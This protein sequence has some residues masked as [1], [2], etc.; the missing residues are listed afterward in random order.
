MEKKYYVYV[1]LNPMRP[2]SYTYEDLKFDFEPFYVGKGHGFRMY[3]HLT[4]KGKNYLKT[5]QIKRILNSGLEPKIIKLHDNLEEKKAFELE[6]EIIKKI[7]RIDKG[8]GCLTNLTDGGDGHS[9]LIQSDETKKKRA[10]SRKKSTF[11]KTMKSKEFSNKMSKVAK[12]RFEDERERNKISFS[13]LGEKNP[14]FGKTTSEKQKEAV[15]KAHKEGK[16]KL[17]DEGRK[18]LIQCGKDRKGKKNVNIRK[19]VI[20]YKLTSPLNEEIIIH[21]AQRL[22]KFCKERKLQYHILKN[23]IGKNIDKK[24]IKSKRLFAKNTLGWRI[25]KYEK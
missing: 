3:Y 8:T 15:R 17:T 21:G 6:I 4:C 2:G 12:K 9:G 7:G 18:K 22:Q 24:T 16:V 13:K 11:Y 19:D 1:Y 5:R 20:I 10:E 23:N 14:M 25:D